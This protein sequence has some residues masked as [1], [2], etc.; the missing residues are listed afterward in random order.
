MKKQNLFQN[1]QVGD[2]VRVLQN[3][4]FVYESEIIAINGAKH[5]RVKDTGYFLATT[6]KRVNNPLN[7][8]SI[9]PIASV[10]DYTQPEISQLQT[11]LF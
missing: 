8:Y 2:L 1:P 4:Q 6:G 9:E 10:I 5:L 7:A 3:G 11:T